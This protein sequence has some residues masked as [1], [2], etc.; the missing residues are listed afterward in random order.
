MYYFFSRKLTICVAGP[1]RSGKTSF[2]KAFSVDSTQV[3][4]KEMPTT[5]V[6][7][8]K[9]MRDSIHGMLYDI[10][11]AN[12]YENLMDFYYR[13]SEAL[14][15]VVDSSDTAQLPAAKR[16]LGNIIFNNRD[17]KIPVLVLCTH[18]D[19]EDSQTCQEIALEIGIDALLGRDL[20][21]YSV[22]SLTSSNFNAV[23]SWV[24]RR[25]K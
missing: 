22:S 12:E 15:F 9:F 5:R 17:I 13:N 14:F 2:C 25:A 21:C 6:Q 19:I 8:R 3:L 18:N 1:P 20:A 24:S 11:G 4:K 16:L 7:I 23:M 10:G